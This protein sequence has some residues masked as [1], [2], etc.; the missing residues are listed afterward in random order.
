M[1]LTFF[2]RPGYNISRLRSFGFNSELA[3]FEGKQILRND[4]S[5][6]IYWGNQSQSIQGEE[7]DKEIN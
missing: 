6:Y 1:F 7:P 2:A 5:V 3:L 4:S